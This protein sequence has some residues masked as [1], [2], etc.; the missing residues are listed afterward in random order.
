M[1]VLSKTLPPLR[2]CEEESATPAEDA[3]ISNSI[4][5]KGIQLHLSRADSRYSLRTQS[6][7]HSTDLRYLKRSVFTTSIDINQSRGHGSFE[8][9]FIVRGLDFICLE[10]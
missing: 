3:L 4:N 1:L 10:Q 5:R 8:I 9:R 2:L 6:I 7:F